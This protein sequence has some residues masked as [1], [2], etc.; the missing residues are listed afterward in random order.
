MD[1]NRWG[2]S[3]V[4]GTELF[5]ARES[6]FQKGFKI[7]EVS[8]YSLHAILYQL[9]FLKH[10]FPLDLSTFQFGRA[11]FQI[12]DVWLNSISSPEPKPQ[13]LAHSIS[14]YPSVSVASCPSTF[15]NI[16]SSETKRPL[17][18][19]YLASWHWENEF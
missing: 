10:W 1:I 16:F 13:G 19:T 2:I 5:S 15:A 18:T 6:T 11:Y 12:S 3:A 8:I 7:P 17:G 14:R 9:I 4:S